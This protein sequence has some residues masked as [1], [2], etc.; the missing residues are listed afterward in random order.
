MLWHRFL[1]LCHAPVGTVPAGVCFVHSP[2]KQTV[3]L[4]PWSPLTRGAD[5][6]GRVLVFL[7]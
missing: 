3:R 4:S 7:S 1:L 5:A 6:C 2:G